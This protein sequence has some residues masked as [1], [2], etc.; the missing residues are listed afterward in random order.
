RRRRDLA[1]LVAS[2]V[3]LALLQNALKKFGWYGG[4]TK[5][6][7]YLLPAALALAFPLAPALERWPRPGMALGALGGI[8]SLIQAQTPFYGE[9][10]TAFEDVLAFGPRLRIFYTVAS[11][12]GTTSA[13]ELAFAASPFVAIPGL[14]LV[15]RALV[16]ERSRLVGAARAVAW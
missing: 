13:D 11:L 2:V 16:P 10:R 4:T 3:V 5:G 12:S 1:L 15:A 7:R 6:P 14:L 8:V 9:Y